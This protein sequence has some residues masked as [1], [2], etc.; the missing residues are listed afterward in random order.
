MGK[1]ST[2]E[3]SIE[4]D[5]DISDIYDYTYSEFG[6]DQAIT[7][8]ADLEPVLLK[9]VD[10]PELGRARSEIRVGLR[11]LAYQNHVIFYRILDTHIRVVRVLHG[12]RD[13]PSTLSQ[14]END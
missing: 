10:Y 11:S 9:L 5:Q 13:L 2:Y 6:D 3:L 1:I 14:Y 4:A 7:Y 12:S 8:L